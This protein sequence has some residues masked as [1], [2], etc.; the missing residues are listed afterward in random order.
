MWGNNRM[1]RIAGGADEV[2]KM[3]ITR[4][5]LRRFA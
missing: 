5:E 1:L 2:H 3:V 4:R